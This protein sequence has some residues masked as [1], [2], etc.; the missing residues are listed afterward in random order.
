MII[1]NEILIT[2]C[3]SPLP[4]HGEASGI[5][6]PLIRFPA[7]YGNFKSMQ[8][9]VSQGQI[10]S[11]SPHSGWNR[12]QEGASWCYLCS[13]DDDI[14]TC[15]F[16]LLTCIVGTLPVNF[17]LCSPLIFWKPQSSYLWVSQFVF[18]LCTF[19]RWF[20]DHLLVRPWCQSQLNVAY[21]DMGFLCWVF[22]ESKEILDLLRYLNL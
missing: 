15:S 16:L 4:G 5:G 10:T 11:Q 9:T 1:A 19:L 13:N 2:T 8:F 22:M 6:N 14:R 12:H 7:I 18:W 20:N 3:L 21:L 17:A